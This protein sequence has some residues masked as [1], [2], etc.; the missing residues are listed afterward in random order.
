MPSAVASGG[1]DGEG[2][3][4]GRVG[5]VTEYGGDAKN[6]S[7]ATVNNAGHEVPTFQPRAAKAM[8]SRFLLGQPL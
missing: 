5:Y 1:G 4:Q 6:F 8:I 7:F 2:V 3:G